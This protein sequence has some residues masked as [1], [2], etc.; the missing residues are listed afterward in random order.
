MKIK[1]NTRL[2][3]KIVRDHNA[4]TG[5]SFALPKDTDYTTKYAHPVHDD[6]VIKITSQTDDENKKLYAFTTTVSDCQFRIDEDT[7]YTALKEVIATDDFKYRLGALKQLKELNTEIINTINTLEH[8]VF[9][10]T[11]TALQK[12]DSYD[13]VIR[14]AR[15]LYKVAV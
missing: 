10:D 7:E 11:V 8:T 5:F 4:K 15:K 2:F 14:T 9:T 13:L 3:K 12:E 6:G 1:D